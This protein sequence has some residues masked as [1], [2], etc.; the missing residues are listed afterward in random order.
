MYR[1]VGRLADLGALLSKLVAGWWVGP[2]FKGGQRT[3]Y[4]PRTILERTAKNVPARH[5]AMRG[6]SGLSITV[7]LLAVAHPPLA[8]GGA[9]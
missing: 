8:G 9:P 2:P 6:A 3:D 4:L 7:G 5:H 1:I